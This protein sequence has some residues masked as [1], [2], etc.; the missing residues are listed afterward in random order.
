MKSLKT[1]NFTWG[2]AGRFAFSLQENIH[3]FSN[4]DV[5]NI[6]FSTSRF[7]I[8]Y[9]VVSYEGTNLYYTRTRK[10]CDLRIRRKRQCEENDLLQD[11]TPVR[12]GGARWD[13]KN[14]LNDTSRSRNVT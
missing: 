3:S 8:L 13:Y 1:V 14:T 4:M 12:P 10:M 9:W 6:C 7:C 11:T 2:N 5:M